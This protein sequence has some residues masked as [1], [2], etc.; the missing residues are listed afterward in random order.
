MRS[1]TLLILILSLCAAAA[2]AQPAAPTLPSA[3]RM[4]QDDGL[5]TQP[6]PTVR[7]EG[8][9]GHPSGGAPSDGAAA[10]LPT[11]RDEDLMRNRA[12][13]ERVL[14][15]AMLREDWPTLERVMSFYPK[16][17]GADPML[18]DYVQGALDRRAGR[19]HEAIARY[20]RMLEQDVTLSYVRLDLAAM[21]FENRAYRDA[22][23]QFDAVLRDMRLVPAAR[24]SAERYRQALAQRQRWTGRIALGHEWTNNVQNASD[25]RFLYL[26]IGKDANDVYYF[27]EL[28][29]DPRDLPRSAH[30]F[31]VS[32][33]VDREF[34]VAGNHFLT[35]GASGSAV[36][37][38]NDAE[39]NDVN[40][41]LRA[42]WRYQDLRTWYAL[43]ANVGRM[44][45]G[46]DAY[47]RHAGITAE[48]GRW[49]G[50]RW[51]VSGAYSWLQRRYASPDYRNYEGNIQALSLNLVHLFPS[52]FYVFAG[53]ALQDEN[54]HGAEESSLRRTIQAG[55]AKTF[56]N[57][58]GMRASL[59]ATHRRFDA[60]YSLF[61]RQERRDRE[62]QFDASVWNRDWNLFG[63]T[64]R[65]D[66]SH[67][68][69]KSSLYA[70][71][72][73]K[74]QVTLSL[75]KTF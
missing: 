63:M 38:R 8:P 32:G 40:A 53:L 36:Q 51:Q 25:N 22:Q 9:I 68:R 11:L 10:S 4:P 59:R 33:N 14:N 60:P 30:G 39:Y 67:L 58:V 20:R 1:N 12:L 18:V 35:L 71:S 47:S 15:T 27:W 72:R 61:L 2:V 69:V 37:Y 44:W 57:G 28:E 50:A 29:K 66:F 16:M 26:P 31:S 55:F 7:R 62:Y 74:R 65:L 45:L 6:L 34:N 70:Y 13:A 54:A 42:G 48:H 64:P 3:V 21:L 73:N 41:Q 23:E 49:L 56:D 43:G 52:N 17:A 46:G 5:I 19:H 75:E 24:Q